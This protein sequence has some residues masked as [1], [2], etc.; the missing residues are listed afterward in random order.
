LDQHQTAQGTSDRIATH[1]LIL[2]PYR[3]IDGQGVSP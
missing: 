2:A 1:Y 3:A